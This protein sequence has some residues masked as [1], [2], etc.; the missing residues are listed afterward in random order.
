VVQERRSG[1]TEAGQGEPLGEGST[2]ELALRL[3]D[4]KG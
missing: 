2:G 3:C 1:G 4:S